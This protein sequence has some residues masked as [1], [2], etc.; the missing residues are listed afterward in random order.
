[1]PFK[2]TAKHR[3]SARRSMR[4]RRRLHRARVNE[5]NRLYRARQMK[6]DPKGQLRREHA[7]T[8]RYTARKLHISVSTLLARRRK[9]RKREGARLRRMRIA[10]VSWRKKKPGRRSVDFKT[11]CCRYMARKRAAQKRKRMS[12]RAL[13]LHEKRLYKRWVRRSRNTDPIHHLL[14]RARIRAQEKG[15]P[16]SISRS[17]FI[18]LPIRCPILG[19]KLTYCGGMGRQN[20]T[21][22]SLDR[23]HNDRG[24]VP[25]N[26]KII[27]WR[28]N[29]LKR[30]VTLAEIE[31]I[32]KYMRSVA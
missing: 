28:A 16:F 6:K 23:V 21:A 13:K 7:A 8:L 31:A 22:A 9:I 26:V 15:V 12:K 1:M 11:Y 32:A 3:L 10:W 2:T 17:E 14:R 25:G 27:S 18:T 29:A 30:D 20:Q 24:Y 19:V 5:I 4:R